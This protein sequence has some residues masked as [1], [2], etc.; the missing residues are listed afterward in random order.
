[1]YPRAPVFKHRVPS[2]MRLISTILP[3]KGR[4]VTVCNTCSRAGNLVN[5]IMNTDCT[6]N[7]EQS[8]FC[9][10]ILPT[11]LTTAGDCCVVSEGS[12]LISNCHSQSAAKNL[13]IA[14]LQYREWRGMSP[15]QRKVRVAYPNPTEYAALFP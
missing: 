15:N 4:H 12:E 6:Y 11:F 8:L 14:G 3:S 13:I 1:M 5:F 7:R 2:Y 10:G 9:T